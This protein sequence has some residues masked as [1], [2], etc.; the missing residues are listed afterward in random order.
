MKR[1]LPVI[2]LTLLVLFPVF[3]ESSITAK[4][5]LYDTAIR[6]GADS[7]AG[8]GLGNLSVSFNQT[9]NRNVKSRLVLNAATNLDTAAG[10][11]SFPDDYSFY[12]SRAYVKFRF[13]HLRSVIGKAPFSWGEGLIFNAGDLLFGSSPI[14]A[15]LMQSEF[16][17]S[18][19]W[20]SSLN[21]PLGPFSFIEGL[22]LPPDLLTEGLDSAKEGGRIVTKL[23]GTKLEAGYLYNGSET[24]HKAYAALQGN[25]LL[26]WHLSAAAAFRNGYSFENNWKSSLVIT[27]G[28]YSL[29]SIGYNGT[30]NYRL[31]AMVK[32]Y[33]LW[34]ESPAGS[35]NGNYGI[36]LYPEVS[37]SF[38]STM[39]LLLRSMISPVDMSAV[40]IPGFTWNVFQGFT[41]ITMGS[42]GAGESNDTFAWRPVSPQKSG[43][44]IM[45]GVSVVY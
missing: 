31:E 22:Y 13:P 11:G 43:L 40:I 26:D 17:D 10:S 45:A 23:A 29:R 5:E 24:L 2:F 15:N 16:T 1:I 6:L 35:Q 4:M 27:G 19:V 36:Y 25:L 7:W 44:S 21:F 28:V 12:I 3:G 39:V 18:S 37:Y 30:L 42:I 38:N 34:E 9:N 33:E 14:S 8:V 41:I 32:P 20:M